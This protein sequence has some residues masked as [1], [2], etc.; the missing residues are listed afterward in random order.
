MKNKHNEPAIIQTWL[1]TFR[2]IQC[3]G[4]RRNKSRVSSISRK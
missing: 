2:N 1:G 4:G 3:I